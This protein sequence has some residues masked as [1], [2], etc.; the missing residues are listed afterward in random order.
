MS[1]ELRKLI[2][3]TGTDTE[4][5]KT[6]ATAALAAAL[7][8]ETVAVYKPTQTG[9]S[10]GQP[11]DVEEVARLTGVQAVA[12]GIRLREPM[13]PVP[14]AA[15]ERRELPTLGDHIARIQQLMAQHD[16]VLVEGAGGL[17]VKLDLAGH[18][19][20]DL[21]LA[22]PESTAIV[23]CRSAL[24]TLNHTELTLE[25]L[26]HRGVSEPKLIIG[27]W[28][29]APDRIAFSNHEYLAELRSELLGAIPSGAGQL[30]AEQ[31][32]AG[33]RSWLKSH[34]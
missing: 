9:V 20:A 31:F 32:R 29:A 16:R 27:S 21:M 10:A 6:I 14:A 1:Q 33:A 26:R 5:G 4:V 15:A 2:F 28:P 17:L 22:F 23:V 3:V 19:L 8:P 11:G 7:H 30:S 13:A 25:A 18:T 34:G 24:G 12:E